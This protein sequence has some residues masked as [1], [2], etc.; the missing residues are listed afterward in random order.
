LGHVECK[1]C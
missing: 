1:E